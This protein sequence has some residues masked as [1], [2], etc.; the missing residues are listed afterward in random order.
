MKCPFCEKEGATST[1]RPDSFSTS[2]CMAS[3]PGLYDETGKW[4]PGWDPNWSSQGYTCS[5][6]HRYMVRSRQGS[7]DEITLLSAPHTEAANG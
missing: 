4:V 3:S 7:P 6:G 1:L 2:T 5:R